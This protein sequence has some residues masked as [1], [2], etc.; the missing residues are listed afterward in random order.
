MTVAL[1]VFERG[2]SGLS[3]MSQVEAY[4]GSTTIVEN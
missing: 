2:V 4:N 1:V 3:A